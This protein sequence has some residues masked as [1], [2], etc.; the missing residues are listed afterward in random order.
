M[1]TVR[2]VS[3]LGESVA[4]VPTGTSLLEAAERAGAPVGHSCGGA[5]GCSTCHLWVR[6]GH[7]SLSEPSDA[8]LDRL[9]S[10][11]DVRPASRL[12]CQALVGGSDVEAWITGESL[13]AFLDE[14][15]ELRRQLEAEGRWPPTQ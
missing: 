13:G 14:H 11:F 15:P 1:P 4:Q 3:P 5:C 6:T 7:S 12:A 8:E 10:A 9:D 2:F